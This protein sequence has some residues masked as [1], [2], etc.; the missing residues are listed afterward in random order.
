[1]SSS[2]PPGSNSVNVYNGQS[3][4]PVNPPADNVP[5]S[6]Y[7]GIYDAATQTANQF[8]GSTNIEDMIMAVQFERGDILDNQIKG[9]MGDVEKRNK[10]LQEANAAMTALRNARPNNTSDNVDLP[11]VMFKDEKGNN[12][13]IDVWLCN[14]GMDPGKNTNQNQSQIDET[15]QSMK[16]AVDTANSTSQMDMVRLQGLMDKRSQTYDMISNTLQKTD[17]GVSDVIDKLAQ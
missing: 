17:K 9:Q 4:G 2:I 14:N 3:T 12:V 7:S 8:G 1:M 10:W 13:S 15:L 6:D 5:P 16:G 11:G